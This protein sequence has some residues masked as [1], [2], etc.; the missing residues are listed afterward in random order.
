[1]LQEQ[2]NESNIS[3]PTPCGQEMMEFDNLTGK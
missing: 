1:M 2:L 3:A